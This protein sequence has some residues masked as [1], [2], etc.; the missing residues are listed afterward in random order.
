M[1]RLALGL[2]L[3]LASVAAYAATFSIP[4]FALN[5]IAGD[6]P[7]SGVLPSYDDAYA[8][9]K[10]AGLQSVG[11]IPSRTTV[12]ATVNPL[13]GGQD[14]FTNIQNAINKCPAGQVVQLGAGAF[15]VKT[16]DMPIQISTG[17]TLRGTGACAGSSS[18]Y[19]QTSITV[20][21]GALAYTGG[22]CGTSTTS[23][24][25]CPNGGPA[26]IY[27]SPV[28]LCTTGAG[29]SAATPAGSRQAAERRRSPPTLRKVKRPF[30][31]AARRNSRS[32]NGF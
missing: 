25:A 10:N 1:K 31:S 20:S 6:D 29:P 13:G 28:R 16:A 18:P 24:V 14:D 2:L 7:T 5:G 11:G 3:A 12:C 19:C 27:I 9:W 22:K 23:E 30:R 21:D 32:A 8:N 4:P 15:T 17:I 26:V